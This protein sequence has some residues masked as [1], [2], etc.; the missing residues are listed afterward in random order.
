MTPLYPMRFISNEYY[1]ALNNDE[2]EVY[3]RGI[4]D[5]LAKIEGILAEYRSRLYIGTTFSMDVS[6]V[7]MR[8]H[9]GHIFQ[10]NDIVTLEREYLNEHDAFAVRVMVL[11]DG[12]MQHIAH[13]DTINA[14]ALRRYHGL[15]RA[16]LQFLRNYPASAKYRVTFEW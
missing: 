1:N 8:F 14:R 4:T 3:I 12:I 5:T 2:K 11:K 13:V 16:Q 6:F 10:P 7:G 15:E 9:G